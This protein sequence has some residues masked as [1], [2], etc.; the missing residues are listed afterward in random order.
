MIHKRHKVLETYVLVKIR[1]VV[2]I[3]Y[4]QF[5]KKFYSLAVQLIEQ[6]PVCRPF[7]HRLISKLGHL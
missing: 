4:R 3:L 6:G 2:R 5:S 7:S 1:N